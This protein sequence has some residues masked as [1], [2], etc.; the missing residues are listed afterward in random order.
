MEGREREELRSLP[1]GNTFSL[2]CVLTNRW[3]V[4][5]SMT[6]HL[7]LVS[8]LPLCEWAIMQGLL[9]GFLQV[10]VCLSSLSSIVMRE[11]GTTASMCSPTV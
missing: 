9:F 5:L 2:T 3:K 11:Q 6:S 4:K 8:G 7:C 1:V 10:T